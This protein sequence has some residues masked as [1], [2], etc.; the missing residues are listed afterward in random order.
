MLISFPEIVEKY[1][2]KI[3]GIIQVGAHWAEEHNVYMQLGVNNIVYVEPCQ[4]AFD[5][6]VVNVGSKTS[7]NF[8][9]FRFKGVYGKRIGDVIMFKT[10]CGEV[11][12]DAEMFVSH[13]NQGQSN[14]L[15]KPLLHLD[16]HKEV[17]FTDTEKVAV[18]PLDKLSF[19]K[20]H[21]N[22]LV[23][24]TQGFEGEVL[25]GATETL[26]YIDCIYTECNRGQT[27]EGNMEIEEMDSFL[28]NHNFVRV[29]TYWPS[30]NWTWGDCCYVRESLLK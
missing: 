14:S 8:D 5:K 16:Q 1:K 29:E 9:E 26:K 17:V 21:Y 18:T 30:S 6:M 24:D 13:N 4:D 19:K 28:K 23:M 25:K 22:V 2:L 7:G 20:E 12:E 27:Y 11:E 10:A 15:L 3:K